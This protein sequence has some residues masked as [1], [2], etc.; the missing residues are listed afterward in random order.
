MKPLFCCCVA[1]LVS[2]LASAQSSPCNRASGKELLPASQRR[3]AAFLSS[4]TDVA[5]V[6]FDMALHY[7]KLGNYAKALSTLEE[8]LK[9]TP[10]LNPA[11]EAD[12]KPISGCSSFK[13]L[14]ARIR[15]KYPVV[16]AAKLAYA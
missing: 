16:A 4:G 9:D 2:A 7:A 12:F 6:R 14:V 8:A 11:S 3:F 10:W 5:A 15:K 1:L 13:S